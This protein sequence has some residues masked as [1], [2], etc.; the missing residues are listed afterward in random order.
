VKV[1][2]EVKEGAAGAQTIRKRAPES[3]V[4]M[5]V[6]EKVRDQTTALRT[7]FLLVKAALSLFEVMGLGVQR[8]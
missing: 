2:G 6:T 4:T 1:R 3:A 7:A 8:N 5:A